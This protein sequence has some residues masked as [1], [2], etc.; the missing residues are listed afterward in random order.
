MS[1]HE[2][3]KLERE[4]ARQTFNLAYARECKSIEEKLRR[5]VS[6]LHDPKGLWSIHAY[7]TEKLR[8]TD[9][10]YDYRYSVLPFVFARLL[11]EG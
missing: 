4:I 6:E 2:W 3:S 10:K 9:T 7:L 11:Y 8:G 1:T 5:R